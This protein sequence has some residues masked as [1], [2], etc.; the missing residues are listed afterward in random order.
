M[1]G[2]AKRGGPSGRGEDMMPESKSL[3][4]VLV[5]FAVL[6]GVFLLFV[7]LG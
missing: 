6:L 2:G 7:V 1:P 5:L 4:G 3:A